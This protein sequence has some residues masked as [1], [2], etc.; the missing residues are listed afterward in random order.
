MKATKRNSII[1][2]LHGIVTFEKAEL[3]LWVETALSIFKIS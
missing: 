1:L 3:T 2:M